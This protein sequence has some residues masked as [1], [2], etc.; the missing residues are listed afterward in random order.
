MI[1]WGY[2]DERPADHS[3]IRPNDQTEVSRLRRLFRRGNRTA[4]ARQ[5]SAVSVPYSA[6]ES[7]AAS[8][9]DSIA[10]EHAGISQRPHGFIASSTRGATSET[11]GRAWNARGNGISG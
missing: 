8:R 6:S 11:A 1:P 4:N 10:Q 5:I 9:S 3:A 7:S 2:S